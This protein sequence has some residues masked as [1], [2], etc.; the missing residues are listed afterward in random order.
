[1]IAGDPIDLRC[2]PATAR[3]PVV[4]STQLAPS[5]EADYFRRGRARMFADLQAYYGS[6][7][8]AIVA[9]NRRYGATHLWVRRRAVERELEPAGRALAAL[10][11]AVRA[12]V[13]QVVRGGRP[14]VLSL[15]AACRT[16]RHGPDEV[17]DIR[18]LASAPL[19]T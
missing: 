4:T 14:A 17:Y 9:L 2:L 13:R 16:W 10:G 19:R 18:C 7:A 12:L 15:P 6:S 3:R 11:E 8:A 1:V 5:Y